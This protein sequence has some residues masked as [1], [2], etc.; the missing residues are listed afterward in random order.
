MPSTP[1]ARPHQAKRECRI[2]LVLLKLTEASAIYRFPSSVIA[3]TV[4]SGAETRCA[5]ICQRTD[6]KPSATLTHNWKIVA[7][8]STVGR[9]RGGHAARADMENTCYALGRAGRRV[10]FYKIRTRARP[11]EGLCSTG[12]SIV[13]ADGCIHLQPVSSARMRELKRNASARPACVECMTI[14]S[15]VAHSTF[16]SA[17]LLILR[18][19]C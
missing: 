10:Q 16:S 4:F 6:A 3:S 19:P 12:P 7:S 1:V 5:D 8:I 11:I 17:I 15:L 9:I 2:G 14:E 18:S 13:G